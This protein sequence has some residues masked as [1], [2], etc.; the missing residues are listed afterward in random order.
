MREIL[1][2]VQA[3][4]IERAGKPRGGVREDAPVYGVVPPAPAPMRPALH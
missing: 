2:K 3:Q 1:D 4:L